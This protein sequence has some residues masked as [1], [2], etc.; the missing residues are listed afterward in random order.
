M[1]VPS[2]KL[3]GGG[4]EQKLSIR[5]PSVQQ[6]YHSVPTVPESEALLMKDPDF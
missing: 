6:K 1:R 4:N 5:T 3:N 2:V